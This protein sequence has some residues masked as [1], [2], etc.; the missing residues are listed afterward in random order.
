[1]DFGG[2]SAA[3]LDALIEGGQATDLPSTDQPK[4]TFGGTPF[5][6]PP[7]VELL[8]PAPLRVAYDL[9]RRSPVAP[10]AIKA[11]QRALRVF[12]LPTATTGR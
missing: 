7:A 2:L 12:R 3:T 6:Y 11:A 8:A 9:A 10:S 5:R 4:L 1:M